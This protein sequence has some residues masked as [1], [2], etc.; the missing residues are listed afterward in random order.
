MHRRRGRSLI[1][2]RGSRSLPGGER[3]LRW[4]PART[5]PSEDGRDRAAGPSRP[6]ASTGA[7]LPAWT[8]DTAD[9]LIHRIVTLAGSRPRLSLDD[10]CVAC[11][12]LL[13]VTGALIVLGHPDDEAAVGVSGAAA[14]AMADLEFALGEGPARDAARERQPVLAGHLASETRWPLLVAAVVD[15]GVAAVFALPLGLGAIRVGVLTLLHGEEGDLEGDDLRQALAVADAVTQIVLLMQS[16][17]PT[18]LLAWP[19]LQAGDH[20]AV[21]HQAT[22]MISVQVGCGVDE[23]L[24]RLRARAFASGEPVDHLARRVVERAVRF[25]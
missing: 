10:V 13:G 21:V 24:V 16:E 17:V 11:C 14:Q 8:S 7:P 9:P 22:G 15:D 23:A 1:G 25:E 2:G 4:W 20:R 3:Q 6:R 5:V 19:L 18:G 12:H